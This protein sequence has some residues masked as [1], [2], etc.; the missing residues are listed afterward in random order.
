MPKPKIT[1][2]GQIRQMGKGQ[3]DR[4]VKQV[5]WDELSQEDRVKVLKR[6]GWMKSDS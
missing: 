4:L 3:P 1:N 6:L 5:E 2:P